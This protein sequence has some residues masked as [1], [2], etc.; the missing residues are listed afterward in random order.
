M[1]AVLSKCGLLMFNTLIIYV[2]R[3]TTKYMRVARVIRDVTCSLM[4]TLSQVVLLTWVKVV[5]MPV[6]IFD[7]DNMLFTVI[8]TKLLRINI[9]NTRI[10]Y[11]QTRQYHHHHHHN[12]LPRVIVIIN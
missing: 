10:I 7:L 2:Y 5:P 11:L 8:V 4:F 12:H 3:C 1:H 9:I 6:V